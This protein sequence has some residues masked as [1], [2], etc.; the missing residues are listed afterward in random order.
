L[1]ARKVFVGGI[2]Q[3][4]DQN[5]LYHMFS[6]AGKVKKTWIQ[7]HRGDRSEDSSSTARNHRGFG[8]VIFHEKQSV[9]RMLGDKPSIRFGE[10]V[11][12]EVRRAIGK[13]GACNAEDPEAGS[14][15]QRARKGKG[16]QAPGA[17]SRENATP[18]RLPLQPEPSL[19]HNTNDHRYRMASNSSPVNEM[20]ST[21]NGLQP[22][23]L[24]PRRPFVMAEI[25]SPQTLPTV[26]SVASPIWYNGFMQTQPH[27]SGEQLVHASGFQP[28]ASGGQ[29][30]QASAG[31]TVTSGLWLPVVPPFPVGPPMCQAQALHCNKILLQFTG[32]EPRSPEALKDKLLE[33]APT[34]YDDDAAEEI[35]KERQRNEIL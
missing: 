34:F 21:A 27:A 22:G 33:A 25:P 31:Q 23:P 9:D 16:P 14:P 30:C 7:T 13:I 18:N 12:L 6:K 8:F 35:A 29:P 1:Q 28:Q 4:V 15:K 2:P 26:S 19:D 5:G 17:P 11:Q 24:L 10:D 32:Q 20:T 3:T